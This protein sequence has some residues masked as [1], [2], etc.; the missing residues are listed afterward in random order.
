MCNEET[1]TTT[2]TSE[3]SEF[4]AE[5][6]FDGA[7]R[8]SKRQEA[9]GLHMFLNKGCIHEE[10]EW[11]TFKNR[12]KNFSGLFLDGEASEFSVDDYVKELF[13]YENSKSEENHRVL[14]VLEI[15]LPVDFPVDRY[16]SLAKTIAI[17]NFYGS[18]G[19]LPFFLRIG[20]RGKATYLYMV[21]SERYYY[22]YGKTVKKIQGSD[23]FRDTTTGRRCKANNPNAILVWKKGDVLSKTTVYFSNKERFFRICDGAFYELVRKIRK[24]MLDFFCFLMEIG[25][26]FGRLDYTG[27]KN[28]RVVSRCKAVN[29]MVMRIEDKVS[30][31]LKAYEQ[32]GFLEAKKSLLDEFKRWRVEIFCTEGNCETSCAKIHFELNFNYSWS[33]FFDNLDLAERRMVTMIDKFIKYMQGTTEIKRMYI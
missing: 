18:E 19:V 5:L 7:V 13:Q 15:M 27:T 23:F 12:T 22:P 3:Q 26:V 9:E 33:C 8:A 2:K 29:E 20:N 21:F 31:I 24:N 25:V 4:N 11:E 28:R 1:V 14:E 6:L 30:N 32:A 17:D 16:E 10:S